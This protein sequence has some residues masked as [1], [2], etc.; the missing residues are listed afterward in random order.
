MVNHVSTN[1]ALMSLS[2]DWYS[3]LF[4]SRYAGIPQPMIVFASS[5]CVIAFLRSFRGSI[6]HGSSS[7]AVA[8]CFS[9]VQCQKDVHSFV[10]KPD[11]G[12]I[13][14]KGS[15]PWRYQAHPSSR[16]TLDGLF[17]R[18]SR[19]RRSINSRDHRVAD[20]SR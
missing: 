7:H 20:G 5:S 11:G 10:W 15:I 6:I 12:K 13:E 3:F 19:R 9:R 18:F 4:R 16:R 2:S 17:I 8:L 14:A 1:K